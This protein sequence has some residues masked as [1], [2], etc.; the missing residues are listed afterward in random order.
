MATMIRMQRAGARNHPAYRIVVTQSTSKRDGR[1]IEKVGFYNPTQNPILL[2]IEEER[3]Q[4]WLSQGAKCSESVSTL[5]K[6]QRDGKVA[7]LAGRPKFKERKAAK[8]A[9]AKA[10][11]GEE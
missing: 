8:K 11:G 9:A 2:Q 7:E 6:R 5:F 4:Y 1:F 10:G 3:V